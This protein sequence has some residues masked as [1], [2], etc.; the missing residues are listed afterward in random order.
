MTSALTDVGMR[1]SQTPDWTGVVLAFTASAGP[2]EPA[3]QDLCR[4]LFPATERYLGSTTTYP[5]DWLPRWRRDRRVASPEVL[6]IYLGKQVSPGALP[7]ATVDQAVAALTDQQ[8]LQAIVDGLATDDLDDLLARLE[9]YEEVFPP[10]AAKPACTVLLDLYP[11]LRTGSFG[12]LD[13]GPEIAVARVVLRLLRRVEETART[14]IVEA[15]CADLSGLTGRIRLLQLAGRR[16]N[17]DYERIIPAA[18]SDRLYRQVCHDIRHASPAQ[19]AAERDPLELLATALAEDPGD[20]EDIDRALRD[21]EFVVTLLLSAPAEVRSQPLGS[22]AT[23]TEQIL[24]WDQLRT[25]VRDDNALAELVDRAAAAGNEELGGVVELARKYQSGWRPSLG[26]F[27]G[28]PLVMRQPLS[29]PNMFFSPSAISHGWPAL[30]LRAVTTYEVDPIWAARA[31][32]SG[33]QFHDRLAAFLTGIP[34]AGQIAARAEARGLD[35]QTAGWQPDPDA[36]QFSR[37]AVQRLVLGSDDQPAVILR[38]A[39]FLPDNTG[40]MKLISDILLSPTAATDAK[41]G[42]LGL[43]E[44]RDLMAAALESSAGPLAGQVLH[45]IFGE[46]PPRTNVE[47]YLWSAQGQS[48]DSRPSN[49]LASTIELDTLGPPTRPD[50]P[51]QQGLFA[52]AGDMRTATLQDYRYLSVQALIR[53][54]L[55]WGYLDAPAGLLPLAS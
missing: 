24:R 47:L 33:R 19:L 37:A 35:A 52:V 11:R 4:L 29:I 25:V 42:R 17:P 7:A 30:H 15:L 13:P 23:R 50:Q 16:P 31:D 12:F 5:S 44:L 27:A 26:P 32:L 55:D 21:D 45:S 1:T 40:P 14:A 10:E 46:T 20:R 6:G 28:R 8:A 41:W 2:H 49:T 34:L 39:V 48:S 22:V 18:D 3:V 43:D 53:M 36:A 51:A 38:Y 9:T 54:A